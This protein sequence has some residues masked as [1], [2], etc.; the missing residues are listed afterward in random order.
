M[1]N[2]LSTEAYKRSYTYKYI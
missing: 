2:G 1:Q